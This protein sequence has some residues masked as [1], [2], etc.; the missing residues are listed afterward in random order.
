MKKFEQDLEALRQRIL[1]MGRL[2]QSMVAMSISAMTD[3]PAVYKNVLA[4]EDQ[5]DQMQ[6]AIDREVV[7]LFS[8][9]TPVAADLRFVLSASR[10]NN[11]LER[12]G[13]QAVGLCHNLDFSARHADTAELPKLRRMG[14]TVQT[15]VLDALLAFANKDAGLARKVMEQ[16]DLVDQLND[17]ILKDILN[18]DAQRPPGTAPSMS[19]RRSPRSFWAALWSVWATKPP[20]SAKKLFIWCRAM[21]SAIA[22]RRTHPRNLPPWNR[23]GRFQLNPTQLKWGGK[24]P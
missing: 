15:M 21:T 11:A 17:E 20:T 23:S 16:D 10:I 19:P 5:V 12:I 2:A 7:R 3:L 1:E 14:D 9:Y 8:V 4:V 18:G 22:I 6:L 24:P 13:D